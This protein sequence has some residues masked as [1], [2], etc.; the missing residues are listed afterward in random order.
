MKRVMTMF[1]LDKPSKLLN[2]EMMENAVTVI[3]RMIQRKSFL[4]EVQVLRY[5]QL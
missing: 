4:E 1:I 3:L 2:V 5:A